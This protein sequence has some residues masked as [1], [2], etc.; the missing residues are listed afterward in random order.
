MELFVISLHY[1]FHILF[2]LF[3]LQQ[4]ERENNF[5]EEDGGLGNFN[6]ASTGR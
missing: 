4:F 3:L 2:C 5:T 6:G 1:L